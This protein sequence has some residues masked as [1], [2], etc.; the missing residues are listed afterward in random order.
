MLRGHCRASWK[1]LLLLLTILCEC[2]NVAGAQGSV[3]VGSSSYHTGPEVNSGR[4]R[5]H[6]PAEPSHQHSR[7]SFLPLDNFLMRKTERDFKSHLSNFC[8]S[9]DFSLA[10]NNARHTAYL[11]FPTVLS[12]CPFTTP[13]HPLR[14]PKH[15]S[16]CWNMAVGAEGSMSLTVPR[17]AYLSGSFPSS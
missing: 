1:L 17:T 14:L 13:Q 12:R 2:M 7:F 16:Q 8:N 6:S 3:G 5:A 10:N 4:H 11:S 9:T 15:D